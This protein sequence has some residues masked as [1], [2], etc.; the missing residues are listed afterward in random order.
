[1]DRNAKAEKEQRITIN[2]VFQFRKMRQVAIFIDRKCG[3]I[4]NAALVEITATGMVDIMGP[5]PKRIGCDREKAEDAAQPIVGFCGFEESPVTAIMLNHKQPYQQPTRRDTKQQRQE[6]A[7]IQAPQ[8]EC[9]E[10][11]KQPQCD[12]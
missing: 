4:T 2:S 10:N 8:H 9:K 7:N 1:M 3:N 12:E 11:K 5:F 6:I